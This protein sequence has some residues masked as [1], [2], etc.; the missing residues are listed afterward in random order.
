[1]S[2]T[3]FNNVKHFKSKAK[4]IITGLITSISATVVALAFSLAPVLATSSVIYNN[5]PSPI[6]GN[7]PSMAYQATQT[8]EFGGQ[9]QFAGTNRFNPVVTVFDE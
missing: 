5:I 7:V 8:S 9:V 6:P 1:M 2:Y 4:T 3:N